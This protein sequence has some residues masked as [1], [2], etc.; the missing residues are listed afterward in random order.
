M[1]FENL[2]ILMLKDFYKNFLVD[3]SCMYVFKIG[4]WYRNCKLVLICL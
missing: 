4:L 2:N 3:K 1:Y